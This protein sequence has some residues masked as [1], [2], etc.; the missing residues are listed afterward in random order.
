[1]HLHPK[2]AITLFRIVQEAYELICLVPKRATD[3]LVRI[4]QNCLQLEIKADNSNALGNSTRETN[5]ALTTIKQR[6]SSLGGKSAV[7]YPSDTTMA[8]TAAIPLQRILGKT[9]S[10][11]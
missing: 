4:D 9:S 5:Y 11:A 1:M 8:I 2:A 6:V 10:A 7:I 3:L